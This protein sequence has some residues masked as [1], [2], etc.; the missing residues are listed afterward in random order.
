[1]KYFEKTAAGPVI[2]KM[3]WPDVTRNPEMAGYYIPKKRIAQNPDV[4]KKLDP[5][6]KSL[7]K[8]IFV[9]KPE[10]YFENTRFLTPK[11]Q[12][13]IIKDHELTHYLRDRKGKM[14]RLGDRGILGVVSTMR[15]ELIAYKRS[16][17]GLKIPLK[18]KVKGIL[19]GTLESTRLLYPQGILKAIMHKLR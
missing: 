12:T 4:A 13:K 1:M 11:Q 19:G 16:I 5:S 6:L 14:N 2:Y 17:K 10:E 15:E 3:T 8:G 7:K 18:N 9:Q